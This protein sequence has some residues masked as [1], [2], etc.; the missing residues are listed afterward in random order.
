MSRARLLAVGDLGALL[1]FALIGLAS[2]DRSIGPAGLTRDWLPFAAC[3]T[4]A[5]LLR[6]TWTE[7]R[8]ATLVQAWIIGIPAGVLL[9]ALALRR[10]LGVEQLEFLGVTL[11]TTL[12][13]LL[14]W[15]GTEGFVRRRRVSR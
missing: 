3:Y 5:A 6:H 7:P 10:E 2:H 12:V 11:V 8:L 9:R 13:L 1:V 4:V 14:V 15:R